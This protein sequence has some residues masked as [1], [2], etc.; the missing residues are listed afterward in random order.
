MEGERTL[1]ERT[2]SAPQFLRGASG[3]HPFYWVYQQAQDEAK[4]P[5]GLLGE[6]LWPFG[7]SST[8]TRATVC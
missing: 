2:A 7:T 5:A 8:T 4:A 6:R 1:I 3:N